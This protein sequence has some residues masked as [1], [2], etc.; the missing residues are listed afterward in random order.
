MIDLETLMSESLGAF[1]E[2][3]FGLGDV[4]GQVQRAFPT[5]PASEVRW[6][7]LELIRRLLRIGAVVAGP[8]APD[9]GRFRPWALTTGQVVTRLGTAWDE[10][11]RAPKNGEVA[12][13]LKVAPVEVTAAP[14]EE[15]GWPA[16]A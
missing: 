9:D 5:A 14:V 6:M 8:P 15:M 4:V 13:F 11:G 1:P 16:D 10:L 3:T 2:E 7:T 12:R